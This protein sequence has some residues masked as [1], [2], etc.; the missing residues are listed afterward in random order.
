MNSLQGKPLSKEGGLKM[1]DKRTGIY[2]RFASA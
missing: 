2:V 1:K